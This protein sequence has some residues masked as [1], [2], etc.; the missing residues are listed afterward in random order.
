MANFRKFRLPIRIYQLRIELTKIDPTIWRTIL[1]PDTIK[2]SK[3]DRVIQESFGWTNSH[4]HEFNIGTKRYGMVN[5]VQDHEWDDENP[6]LDERKF[7]LG[8]L[9]TD[10]LHEF[11]YDYDFGD[12][13][14]HLAKVER[15]LPP[16]QTNYWPM[17]IA[18]ENACPPEDVG[19]PS[20]YTEF[21][22][23]LNDP[24]HAQHADLFHWV[25]GPFDP[26]SFDVNSANARIGRIR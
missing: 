12:G 25:G 6:L 8:M 19:G 3:L 18:G 20:G 13:W 22:D 7:T 4:L 1:V 21:L 5:A 16:N 23:I 26:R 17:C 10:S 14:C 2:L 24:S 9:L 15:Q 11:E